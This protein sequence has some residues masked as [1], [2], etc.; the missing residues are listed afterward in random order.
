[1][2]EHI[3][4]GFNILLEPATLVGL[5]FGT[6]LGIFFGVIPGLNSITA[7]VLVLPFT[8]NFEST[9]SIIILLSSYCGATYAG[10][11]PS[12]LFKI[13]GTAA[14]VMTSIDGHALTQKGYA[15]EA[16]AV[17]AV[18]SSIGGLLSALTLIWFLPI[19]SEVAL[20]FGPGQYLAVA[21]F[22]MSVITSLGSKNQIKAMICLCLGL[23]V[24]AVGVDNVQGNERFT[25]GS[26]YLLNG[27]GIVPVLTGLLAFSELFK[28][29]QKKWTGGEGIV[30]NVSTK[31]PPLKELIR[32]WPT[33]TRGSILGIIIGILPGEGSVISSMLAYNEERR[34]MK[35]PDKLGTGV[36]E[37]VAAPESANNAVT[38]SC[39]IPTMALGIPGS[40]TAAVLI[41][42]FLMQ[43]IEPG[44]SLIFQHREL[45]DVIFAGLIACNILIFFFGLY[46][47]RLLSKVIEAPYTIMGPL[48][49]LFCIWGTF[50]VSNNPWDIWVMLAFG[51]I[52]YFLIKHEFPI[53][54]FVLGIILGPLAESALA[55]S[56]VV[57]KGNLKSFFTSPII[58]I[59]LGLSFLTLIYPLIR[60][61]MNKLKTNQF[62]NILVAAHNF[63]IDKKGVENGKSANLE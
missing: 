51:I 4:I 63:K 36:Y 43:G 58:T 60:Y 31:M 50:S 14:A 15:G 17:S 6:A 55:H 35:N 5:I 49:A 33:I 7:V 16:L 3:I 2:F 28:H 44:P 25:F 12:I 61:L 10:S 32:L 34:W 57:Y 53:V 20:A 26:S 38:G 62:D 8:N 9:T 42:A 1:M 29:A 19:L 52:G 18:A 13:P 56:V 37:G 45:V 59:L 22:G 46:G 48:I 11:V 21:V 24:A 54:P 23:L 39:M 47:V 40:P 27:F 41:G 30:K